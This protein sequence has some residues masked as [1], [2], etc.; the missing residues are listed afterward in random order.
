MEQQTSVAQ[1][2][3]KIVTAWASIG[4]TSW[5]EFA[6]F[7]AALYTACLLME[8]LWKRCGRPFCEEQG[9][10]KRIKRRHGDDAD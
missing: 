2:V 6:S 3:A 4:L 5:A 7:M 10:I 1:P 9:W 8:W